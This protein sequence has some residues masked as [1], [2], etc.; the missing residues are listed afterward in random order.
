MILIETKRIY[1]TSDGETSDD[2]N[3]AVVN[4]KKRLAQ[5][6]FTDFLE[7]Q[8]GPGNNPAIE[9]VADALTLH[10]E[11]ISQRLETLKSEGHQIID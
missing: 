5:S 10:W 2:V 8:F 1:V 6:I 4:Y 11:E 3:V 9:D 7:D